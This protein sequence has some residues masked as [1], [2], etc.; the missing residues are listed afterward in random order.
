MKPQVGIG[1]S[2]FWIYVAWRNGGAWQV[3]KTLAPVTIAFLVSFALY[4]LWPLQLIGMGSNPDNMSAWPWVTPI[5]LFLLHRGLVA[6]DKRLS[7]LSSPLLAP[8]TSQFSYAAPLMA[9][10][11]RPKL[12]LAAWVALWI[13]V[14][15]R[16]L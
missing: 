4:G 12:F 3:I 13:P 9:L 16:L 11:S 6:N 15:A 14:L 2:I 8:Y 10:F 1:V 7:I 5:G